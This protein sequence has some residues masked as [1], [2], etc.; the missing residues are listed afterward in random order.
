MDTPQDIEAAI[1]DMEKLMEATETLFRH[2]EREVYSRIPRGLTIEGAVVQ[3]LNNLRDAWIHTRMTRNELVL[4][5]Y[6][7]K[8]KSDG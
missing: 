2:F 3:D 4:L 8:G 7:M 6:K 1:I 5:L